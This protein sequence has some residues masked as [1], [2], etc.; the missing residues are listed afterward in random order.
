MYIRKKKK[1]NSKSARSRQ[2]RARLHS[3]VNRWIQ[4]GVACVLTSNS[5]RLFHF[6]K[7]Q[8]TE[9]G[10]DIFFGW[11]PMALLGVFYLVLDFLAV[12]LLRCFK[13]VQCLCIV[14]NWKVRSTC[15]FEYLQIVLFRIQWFISLKIVFYLILFLGYC[16]YFYKRWRGRA[17]LFSILGRPNRSDTMLSQENY[18]KWFTSS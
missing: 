17:M 7:C 5:E 2:L 8:R 1:K 18:V 12:D 4:V 10:C 16:R 11:N 3:P 9:F 13:V 15:S 14:R 6:L